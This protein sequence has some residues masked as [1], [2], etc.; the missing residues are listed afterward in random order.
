MRRVVSLW[1]PYWPT[2]RLRRHD[3]GFSPVDAPLVTRAHDGR[4]MVVAAACR[5]AGIL[6]LRAGMPLAHAQAMVPDLA[7]ANAR[8]GEDAAA[9]ERLA[10]WCLCLSPVTL[11]RQAA[12]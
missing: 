4:R 11:R 8:P 6:G 7:V 1:L 5:A 10:V 9:L 3:P 12:L 2:D